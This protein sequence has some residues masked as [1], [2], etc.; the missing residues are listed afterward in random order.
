ME[1]QVGIQVKDCDQSGTFTKACI[2]SISN[3]ELTDMISIP[4]ISYLVQ[5]LLRDSGAIKR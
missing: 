5:Q 3:P 1:A 2:T 4:K